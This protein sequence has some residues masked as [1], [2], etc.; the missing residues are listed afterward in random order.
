MKLRALAL[1]LT[2]LPALAQTPGQLSQDR[3]NN[4]P[5]SPSV[6]TLR[7]QG[8]AKRLPDA[9]ATVAGAETAAN[10]GE[11]YGVRLRGTVTPPVTGSYTFFISGD[12]GTELL[13]SPDASPFGKLREAWSCVYTAPRQWDKFPTQRSRTLRLSGNQPYY[14]EALM[15]EDGGADHLSLGWSCE[16]DGLLAPVA[17]GTPVSQ[18]WTE[19]SPGAWQA[20]VDAGDI[21]NTADCFSFNC[22][23]W[24]G[25]GE[26]TVRV[27]AMNNPH[28]WAKAGIM[29][30]ASLDPSGAHA[31]MVRSSASGMSFQRRRTAAASSTGTTVTP[32]CEWVRLVRKGETITAHTSADGQTWTQIGSDTFPGLPADLK[33]GLV[34][35]DT[36]PT[37][38]APLNATF[39][40]ADFKSLTAREII[41]TT[42]LASYVPPADDADG[43]SLPDS[44]ETSHNLSADS[45]AGAIGANGEHG[46]PD[47]DGISNFREYLLG[48]DP[49]NQEELASCLTRETWW[50]ITGTTVASLTSNRTRFLADP[51]TRDFVPGPS[52]S[53]IGNYYGTRYRGF[54]TATA[55]GYHTFWI[56][57]DNEAELWLA[58]GSVKHPLTAANLTNRYG[59]Q[60]IALIR[61]DR[62]DIN[63]TTPGDFDRYAT[64]RSRPVHLTAGQSY[65]FEILHKESAGDDHCA[66]AW[67]PPGQPRAFIP[68]TAFTA[69]IPETDDP[70]DDFLP[71][72]WETLTPSGKPAHALDPADNGWTSAAD[73]QYG[74]PDQDGLTNLEEFQIGTHPRLA[75]TDGD[76]WSDKDERDRYRT[77]PL[78]SN[79]I[80]PGPL[81]TLDLSAPAATSVPWDIRP[82][83][84][85]VAYERRGWTDY[86]VTVAPGD[87]G[88]H[89]ITLTGG[90]EG[91]SVRSTE[92]L[93]ISFGLD[94]I[95]LGRQTMVCLTGQ[96]TTLKQLTPWLQ[97]GTHTVRVE[98]HNVRAGC[99][100]RINS[101]TIRRLGGPATG[102]GA[103]PLW[104]LEKLQAENQLTRLP[105]ASRTSPACI[106]G[107]SPWSVQGSVGVPPASSPISFQ[108]GPDSIFY[109][110]IPLDPAAATNLTIS[111]QNGALVLPH[112]ITWTPTNLFDF[113]QQEVHIRKGDSLLLDAWS[114]PAADAQPFH[115][116]LTDQTFVRHNQSNPPDATG[117]VSGGWGNYRGFGIRFDDAA[118]DTAPAQPSDTPLLLRS[119]VIRRSATT[120]TAPGD[121]ANAILKIYKSQTPS[122]ENWI[123]DSTNTADVRGGISETNLTF[124]FGSVRLDPATKYWFHFANTAGALPN[125]QI[126]WT[127]ARL[128][129]SNNS[130]HTFTTGNLV[131]TSWGNQDTAWDPLIAA[132]FATP[133]A[134]ANQN[135]T[136][137][138]GSPFTHQFQTPGTFTLTATHGG[139]SATATLHV[140]SAYFGPDF[141]VQ[142]YNR[143]TWTLSGLTGVDIQPSSTLAWVE[144]TSPLPV[145]EGQGEGA[146]HTRSF[147]VDAYQPGLHPVLARV[148]E[149]G[150][151][152]AKGNVNA[153]MVA[154]ASETDDAQV[155]KVLAD[156]NRVFHFTLVTDGMPQAVE[157]QL[158]TYFQGATFPDGGRDLVLHPGDFDDNGICHVHIEWAGYSGERLCHTLRAILNH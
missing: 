3:W 61:D 126:T 115:V 80:Q 127:N 100:L 156:G 52:G 56:S 108:T 19:T 60:K 57:G 37:G 148:P 36:S 55:T 70:D 73:G 32:A 8:I 155:V 136:H 2:T 157:F 78:V 145:G 121:P 50:N 114:G 4:L 77:N 34:A 10:A 112:S 64:Q 14:L 139:Q 67:Q 22:R 75:D 42:Q 72:A 106:E 33:V 11:R 43:D 150:D 96:N 133:L 153:F 13:L 105:S 140:H 92:K 45:A 16:P 107:V 15:T 95:L 83:G 84:S 6:L 117:L 23:D 102:G 29:V 41:P 125:A 134:A 28:A 93:P 71:S 87:E 88:I 147:T 47:S 44:W 149:T 53:N 116:F 81:T 98:N 154:R 111:M 132:S 130:A 18:T 31:M 25:D 91:G 138:A 74:D 24:S 110:D 27:T 135:T 122:P 128:R 129:V 137:T 141:I 51:D 82:D 21:W 158:A 7:E 146:Q 104:I 86:T 17:I 12:D 39:A 119:L 58:D 97:A 79:A 151:I 99:N 20:G 113:H 152:I 68:A 143:R 101:L 118:L 65:Y 63:F 66:V 94:G 90:A 69:D 54:I 131:N 85:A 103:I 46:D 123:A 59:K 144:T 89:E 9:S 76:G 142:T 49:N 124:T 120:G 38:T 1:I 30:R 109:A 5:K 35:T 40:G 48:T 62:F 26:F